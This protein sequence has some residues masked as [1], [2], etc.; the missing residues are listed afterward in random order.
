MSKSPPSSG[1]LKD[2]EGSNVNEEPALVV[3]K[4]KGKAQDLHNLG[5]ESDK[6]SDADAEEE[7]DEEAA[8][9]DAADED[10]DEN[11]AESEDMSVGDDGELAAVG[12]DTV[13]NEDFMATPRKATTS[14]RDPGRS[15]VG[16]RA[17]S[18]WPT[19]QA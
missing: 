7:K 5:A 10:A 11:S 4:G 12:V 14:K 3:D 8:N 17:T 19:A 18:R 1:N 6:D 13:I 9:E 15:P 16:V 2:S